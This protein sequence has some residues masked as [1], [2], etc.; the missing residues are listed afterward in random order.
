M[1]DC[2]FTVGCNISYISS[3]IP[4]TGAYS[5]LDDRVEFPP[6]VYTRI[7]SISLLVGTRVAIWSVGWLLLPYFDVS[8]F[9]SCVACKISYNH[10]V[11]Y[12]AMLEVR[13][14][15]IRCDTMRCPY[16]TTVSGK[17]RY[18]TMRLPIVV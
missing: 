13:Y 7:R 12:D 2:E 9:V 15:S 10:T 3:Y 8:V 6:R 16:D 18:D 17:I 1:H 11:R 14:D 4:H 5:V